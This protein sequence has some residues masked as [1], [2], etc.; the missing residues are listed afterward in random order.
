MKV[1]ILPPKKARKHRKQEGS[2]FVVRWVQGSTVHFQWFK[3]DSAACAFQEQLIEQG[4][5]PRLL[6]K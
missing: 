5:E 2:R 1:T 6:M 3:R 4:Y